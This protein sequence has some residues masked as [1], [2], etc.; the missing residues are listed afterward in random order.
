[1][2]DDAGQRIRG[3]VRRGA[4]TAQQRL[5]PPPTGR[6]GPD[7]N[8]YAS[9]GALVKDEAWAK[10]NGLVWDKKQLDWVRPGAS[11]PAAGGGRAKRYDA[12]TGEATPVVW[13]DEQGD[14]VA[15]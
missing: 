2:M 13:S 14:W 3:L 1:M 12:Y 8:R 15:A 9:N 6:L 5:G 10:R 11:G 4:K 7:G